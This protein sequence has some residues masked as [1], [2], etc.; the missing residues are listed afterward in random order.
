MAHKKL[1]HALETTIRVIGKNDNLFVG[2]P[3]LLAGGLKGSPLW[4]HVKVLRLTTNVRVQL[5]NDSSAAEFSKK[6]LEI[7]N[8]TLTVDATTGMITMKACS[9]TM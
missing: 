1:L 4:R 2:A 8:G 7:G 5:Q 9:Q 6:L 3:I